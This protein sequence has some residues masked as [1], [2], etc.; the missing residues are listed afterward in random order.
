[1][2]SFNRVQHGYRADTAVASDHIRAPLFQLGREGLRI[3]PVQAIAIFIDRHLRHHWNLRV[4]VAGCKNRL[5]E[6]F[7]ISEGFENQQV[8]AAFHQGRDLLTESIVSLLVRSLAQWL[9]AD[10]QRSHGTSYPQIEALGSLSSQPGAGEIDVTYTVGKTV[11]GQ[12]KA[13]AAECVG[14]NYLR[15]GLQVLVMNTA[16]E[17]GLRQVQFVIAAINENP[18]GIQQ[19]P[20]RAV[21]QHRRC[22]QMGKQV[23]SH[24][25]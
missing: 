13:I 6:F 8:H 11:T 17:I 4:H 1:M 25:L 22:F 5:M 15:T 20:H 9:N 23:R 16:D 19:G 12:P 21:T 24:C 3:R 2:H 18:F 7:Q 10:A 14:L